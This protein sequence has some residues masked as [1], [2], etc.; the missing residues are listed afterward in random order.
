V[1]P[2]GTFSENLSCP[3]L[4]ISPANSTSSSEISVGTHYLSP[5]VQ[6][7]QKKQKLSTDNTYTGAIKALANLIKQSIIIISI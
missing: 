2:E 3:P 6:K 7:P 4:S 1:T 5:S